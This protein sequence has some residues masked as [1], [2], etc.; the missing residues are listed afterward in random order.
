MEGKELEYD[1]INGIVIFEEGNFKLE[2]LSGATSDTYYF[3]EFEE[4]EVIGNIHETK[5][6]LK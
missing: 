1:E 2:K 5:E 3:E 6:F 4:F